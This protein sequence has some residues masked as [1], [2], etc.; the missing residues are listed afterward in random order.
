MSGRNLN[1]PTPSGVRHKGAILTIIL[2]GYFMILLDNS[3]NFTAL[4]SLEADLGLSSAELA[5]VQDAYAL[6]FC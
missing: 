2:V 4:P 6:V 3:V 5:W 1:A